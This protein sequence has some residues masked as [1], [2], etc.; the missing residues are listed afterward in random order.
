[1]ILLDARMVGPRPHGIARYALGLV[2]ALHELVS[3]ASSAAASS[4]PRSASPLAPLTAL[5]APGVPPDS[6]LRAIPAVE[7]RVPLYSAREQFL[8]PHLIRGLAPDLLHSLTYAA[9]LASPAPV[10]PTIHDLIHLRFPEHHSA[11]HRLY[12]THV[13]GPLARRAPRVITV[14]EASADAIAERL[15]VERE[16]IVV[17]PLGADPGF[18]AASDEDAER[19]RARRNLPCD[20]ILYVGN[21]RP[22][23]NAAGA[24]RIRETLAREHKLDLPLVLVGV[25]HTVIAAIAEKAGIRTTSLGATRPG[26]AILALHDVA[27]SELPGIYRAARALLMPSLD[28]GFGLPALEAMAAGTPVVAARQGGI[29]EV[30]GDAGLLEDPTNEPA[31]AAAAA[32]VLSDGQLAATLRERGRARAASFTWRSTARRTLDAYRAALEEL[33]G[34]A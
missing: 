30:V 29:P 31:F 27:D 4:A 12:Y 11:I 23:K 22:H 1:M 33:R 7:T 13:V 24:I 15:R 3:A 18:L 2:P 26:G 8:L 14:S 20:F 32:R 21:E 16:R 34:G 10:I 5:I 9:P 17:T 19:V 25:A 6:P 28:E